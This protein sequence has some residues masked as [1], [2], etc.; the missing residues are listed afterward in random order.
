LRF[1]CNNV[2]RYSRD[3]FTAYTVLIA[4]STIVSVVNVVVR[5]V[6]AYKMSQEA[7]ALAQARNK[8]KPLGMGGGGQSSTL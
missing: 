7:N 1:K 6:V 3:L 2:H 4:I 5:L 8:S